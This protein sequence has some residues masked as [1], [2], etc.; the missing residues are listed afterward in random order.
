[1]V[2]D[3]AVRPSHH[4]T[5]LRLAIDRLVSIR[6]S[7]VVMAVLGVLA[8][9]WVLLPGRGPS[10]EKVV[11]HDK[12]KVKKLLKTVLGYIQPAE[13]GDADAQFSI[14]VMYAYGLGL[15]KDEKLA[16]DWF[17]KAAERGNA[18]AQ[19][20]LGWRYANGFGVEK[21]EKRAVDWFREAAKRGNAPAQYALGWRYANGFDVG[22][23]E[24]SA[25]D[26]YRDAAVQGN[27]PAQ[28]HL[29]EIY[30]NRQGMGGDQKLAVDW[31][32]K[33]A[34]QGIAPHN[35]TSGRCTQK[36]TV[37]TRT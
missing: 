36:A 1:M 2:H 16:V 37:W 18:P 35:S 34:E 6:H 30:A 7:I 32:R 10:G 12:P 22:K 25:V 27:A 13:N 11:R 15:E 21:D 23:D 17:R 26:W 29:G 3:P 28:L 5:G 8:V 9:A 20:A 4:S 24:Q 33:A 14:G 19:Y 31:F